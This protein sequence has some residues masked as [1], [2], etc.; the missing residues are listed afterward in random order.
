MGAAESVLQSLRD[1]AADV[2]VAVSEALDSLRGWASAPRPAR[3]PDAHAGE[4][5][6][7]GAERPGE[8]LEGDG[9][10]EPA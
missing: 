10:R 3:A 9:N 4:P 8:G 5:V 2:D 1:T 7:Q 6:A